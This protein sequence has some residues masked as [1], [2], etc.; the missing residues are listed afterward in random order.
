MVSTTLPPEERALVGSLS[1]ME[2]L[3]RTDTWMG[4]KVALGVADM[5]K[6]GMSQAKPVM[7]TGRDLRRPGAMEGAH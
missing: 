7:E 1:T 6:K 3:L 2:A 4:K 5:L